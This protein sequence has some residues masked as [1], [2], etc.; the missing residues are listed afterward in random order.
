MSSHLLEYRQV[1]RASHTAGIEDL[2]DL[3]PGWQ[4][5]ASFRSN[6]EFCKGEVEPLLLLATT[7]VPGVEMSSEP[8]TDR[9]N[10]RR[11]SFAF[12]LLPPPFS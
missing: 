2:C 11:S 1:K 12:M 9:M 3:A 4:E 7:Y 10:R 6:H 5:A 8:Y